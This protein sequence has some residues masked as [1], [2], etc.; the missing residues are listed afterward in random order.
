MTTKPVSALQY[1]DAFEQ[2]LSALTKLRGEYRRHFGSSKKPPPA[3]YCWFK[4][5]VSPDRHPDYAEW[6]CDAAAELETQFLSPLARLEPRSVLDVGCGNGA[7]L[8]RL[9]SERRDLRLCG[10]NFQPAQ[11]R[12]ARELLRGTQAEIIEADFFV[13][14]FQARFDLVCLVESAFHMPDKAELCRRIADVLAPGGEVWLLDIL[15]GERA[16]NVFDGLGRDQTLFNYIP[17]KD[18][19]SHFGAHGI[20]ETELLDLSSSVADFLQVSDVKVLRDQYLLPRMTSTFCEASALVTAEP[21]PSSSLELMVRIAVEYRR[22][23][24]LLRAGMLQYV[25]MRYRR[26]A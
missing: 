24:R 7:L 18:W 9:A 23:S 13:H 3:G 14:K 26:G 1:Y 20:V 16:A 25:L 6:A 19:L 8:R 11:V 10:V 17:R 12:V 4:G 15:V 22:L 5:V 21:E 2:A